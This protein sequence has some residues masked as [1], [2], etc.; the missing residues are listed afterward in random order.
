MACGSGLNASNCTSTPIWGTESQ[1]RRF[2]R[3]PNGGE[4]IIL[5]GFIE[6]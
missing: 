3:I 6:I 4:K 5:R 2:C 1:F